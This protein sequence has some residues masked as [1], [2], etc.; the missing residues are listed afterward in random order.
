MQYKTGDYKSSVIALNYLIEQLEV[1]TEAVA[2]SPNREMFTED[3][4]LS[5]ARLFLVYEKN[6]KQDLADQE[7]Q[8]AVNLFGKEYGIK[9][10]EEMKKFI[11]RV[12]AIKVKP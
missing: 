3:Q 12:D 2:K 1:R 6:G 11:E 7:Y 4:A 10:K 5:H 9:S 8:E